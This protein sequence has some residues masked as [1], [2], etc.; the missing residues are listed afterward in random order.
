MTNY[1][2]QGPEFSISYRFPNVD[3]YWSVRKL[4]E[5]HPDFCPSDD[6]GKQVRSLRGIE[7]TK[8]QGIFL[9]IGAGI[10]VIG[11][12]SYKQSESVK[13]EIARATN[14]YIEEIDRIPL[15]KEGLSKIVQRWDF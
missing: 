6:D 2:N 3:D 9:G 15:N 12:K 11:G 10:M 14:T 1:E 4:V 7:R 8:M 13:G 5:A